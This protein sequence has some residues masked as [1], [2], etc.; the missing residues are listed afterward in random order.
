MLTLHSY[1]RA[2][3]HIDAD[4]FFATCEQAL[5]PEWKG[6]P[7]VCGKERGI[8]ASMSYEA[9]A[10][11]VTRAMKL[12]DIKKIC[13][14]AI[15][16]PS[17]YETYSLFSKRM[18][19]IMRRYSSMV[20]EY[21]ID[22][23]FVD[24]TGLR[25]SLGM[26]Y[27]KIAEKMRDDIVNELGISVSVGLAPSKVLAKVASTWDK[28]M[29]LV[30]IPGKEAHRYLKQLPVGKVWGIGSQ[31]TNYCA[32]LKI[33]SALDF[34]SREP[35]WMTQHFT[36]PHQEIH[37]EL[38]GLS[39]Y[40]VAPEVKTRYVS[41]S[42]TKTFTPPS[43]NK[44]FVW[45]QL[46]KNI[47]NACIKARRYKL[48]ASEIVMFLKTQSFSSKGTKAKLTRVSCFPNEL[49]PVARKLFEECFQEGEEYRSTGVV[50]ANLTEHR[51]TQMGLFEE[52]LK[53]EYMQ[54]L[55]EAVDILSK[56]YGKH[57]VHSAASIEANTFDQ[58]KGWRGHKPLRKMK[59][60]LGE[61]A[62]KRLGM[63][64]LAGEIK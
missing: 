41:I 6:K 50:L 58:H 49:L 12:S 44:E 40:G 42:K 26:S 63:P 37:R 48:G 5:H 52:P 38:R 21:S 15:F 3:V 10:R 18:F 55:Y 51:P 27:K 2:I 31:T 4:S 39:V 20:E 60:M 30:C 32:K 25:R 61:S 56:K 64:L 28:P 53:L 34:A 54:N 47:E 43:K 17:D 1:P 24:I 23:G 13:P 57:T 16:V 59:K 14:D 19:E 8:A 7:V 36:K 33:F 11:G 45:G 35:E 46:V 9:K 62:R 29:G 22:E